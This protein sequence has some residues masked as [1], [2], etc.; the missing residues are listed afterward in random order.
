MLNTMSDVVTWT[1]EEETGN[2]RSLQMEHYL[3]KARQFIKPIEIKIWVPKRVRSEGGI[4]D[5]D[6][7]HP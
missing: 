4:Y 5:Y 2:S 6:P 3:D 1:P 7:P